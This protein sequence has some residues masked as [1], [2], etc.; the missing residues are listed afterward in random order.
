MSTSSMSDSVVLSRL[1]SGLAC[2]LLPTDCIGD[3]QGDISPLVTMTL[4][5]AW[6]KRTLHHISNNKTSCRRKGREKDNTEES[7]KT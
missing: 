1:A 6:D 4:L 2:L 7:L 3:A 5:H